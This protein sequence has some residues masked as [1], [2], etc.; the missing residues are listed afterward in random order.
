MSPDSRVALAVEWRGGDRFIPWLGWLASMVGMVGDWYWYGFRMENG[1]PLHSRCSQ[2]L[3]EEQTKSFLE[4]KNAAAAA[5]G[6]SCTSALYV[7]LILCEYSQ[8][9]AVLCCRYFRSGQYFGDLM[10]HSAVFGYSQCS[11]H[12]GVRYCCCC[13][14]SKYFDYL[15]GNLCN[16]FSWCLQYSGCSY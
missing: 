2:H 9:F 11:N 1:T 3:A 6:T 5:A 16:S 12:F 10:L 7:L 4:K 8:Y 15:F 13:G 14:C